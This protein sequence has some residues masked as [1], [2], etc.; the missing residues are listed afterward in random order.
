M[1]TTWADPLIR[2]PTP[3]AGAIQ[4]RT[5]P[6]VPEVGDPA[7]AEAG[8]QREDTHHRDGD[9]PRA[10]D[11]ARYAGASLANGPAQSHAT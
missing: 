4:E 9:E 7:P 3:V 11:H 10:Q 1:P 8:N 2:R 6:G 5:V